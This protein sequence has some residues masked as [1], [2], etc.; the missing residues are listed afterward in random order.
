MRGLEEFSK[1]P[2]S[3]YELG[4]LLWPKHK[5]AKVNARAVVRE[6]L[7]HGLVEAFGGDPIRYR[8]TDKAPEVL[9]N[10]PWLCRYCSLDVTGT[11]RRLAQYWCRGC[12]EGHSVCRWCRKFLLRAT[13]EFP[14]KIQLQACPGKFEI[15]KRPEPKRKEKPKNVDAVQQELVPGK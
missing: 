13:G 2:L 12:P 9:R 14:Y 5:M 3:A 7:L 6:L 10:P 8:P 4:D 1:R 15:P 11:L